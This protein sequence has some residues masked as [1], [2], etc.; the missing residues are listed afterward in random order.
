VGIESGLRHYFLLCFLG[1]LLL[2]A[3]ESRGEIAFLGPAMIF[4]LLGAPWLRSKCEINAGTHKVL[5]LI[6]TFKRQMDKL[7]SKLNVI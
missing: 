4:L 6:E 1:G 3:R 2:I 5:R 7:K